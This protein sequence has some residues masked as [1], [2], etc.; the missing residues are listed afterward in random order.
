MNKV[1]DFVMRNKIV[2][3][4]ITIVVVMVIVVVSIAS[5]KE[6]QHNTGTQERTA[7]DAATEETTSKQLKE[8]ETALTAEEETKEVQAETET[9]ADGAIAS[10]VTQDGTKI[11]LSSPEVETEAEADGSI[12]YK[13]SDGSKVVIGTNGTA[14]VVTTKKAENES[15]G[16]ISSNQNRQTDSGNANESIEKTTETAGAKEQHTNTSTEKTAQNPVQPSTQV[17][18]VGPTEAPTQAQTQAPTEKPTVCRHTNTTKKVTTQ[19]TATSNGAWSTVCNNCGAILETGSIHYYSTYSVDLGSGQTATV[20]GYYEEDVAA[21]IFRQLNTYRQENGL[22]QLEDRFHTES[23]IRAVECAY[24][25][26]HTRPNGGT[27]WDFG[28]EFGAENISFIS[29]FTVSTTDMAT[30]FM[31]GWKNSPGHN[32]NMLVDGEL[33][34]VGVFTAVTLDSNGIITSTSTYAVQIFG[35]DE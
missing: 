13:M 26:S 5:G 30:G 15:S 8:K 35:S 31:I 32:T 19:A 3:T 17:P 25:F 9:T 10:V 2:A 11:D 34:G 12:T 4:I 33:G 29:N 1:R 18:T 24:S 7:S 23:N 14:K 22:E 20:Y 27:V 28:P 6:K 16:N 21:E